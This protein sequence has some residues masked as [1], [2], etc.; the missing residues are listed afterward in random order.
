MRRRNATADT[1]Q[2]PTTRRRPGRRSG[3]T[4]AVVGVLGAVAA[5]GATAGATTV[6]SSWTVYHGTPSGSGVGTAVASVNTGSRAWTSPVLSGQL[7]GEPLV[8]NGKI[9]VATE[10]NRVYE[11]SP[12]TGKILWS[13]RIATPVPASAL[14]CG[15]IAPTVGITGTPVIDAAR[16]EIFVVADEWVHGHPEHVL[17]GLNTSNGKI[18]MVRAVDPRGQDPALLL[19]RTGLNLDAG[20]V[21]FGFGGNDGD[22]GNYR[23]RVVTV[24]ETGGTPRIFTIDAGAGEREGAIWMGGAA[25]E[26]D[27]KGH[28]WVEVGNGSVTSSRRTFDHSDAVLEFT[29]GLHLTQYFAPGTWAQDNATDNDLSTAPALLADGK[30]VAAGKSRTAYLLNANH[31]GGINHQQAT[32]PG[33]CDSIIAGGDAVVGTTVYL[34]CLSGPVALRVTTSPASLQ[35][36]WRARVGG[37]PP[38][39]VANRVW[40]IGQDGMLYGL[41]PASGAVRQQAAIGA[42]ANHFPTP[43]AGVGLLLAPAANRV[44]AFRAAPTGSARLH[45]AGLAPVFGS[46]GAG[47]WAAGAGALAAAL[48]LAGLGRSSR[49]RRSA[50]LGD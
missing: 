26:V 3:A 30:V 49:R 16:H 15:D 14:P 2:Q 24:R 27:A 42:V 17:V 6:L 8:S 45:G 37:G 43:S 34:P 13:R 19:Q 9:Y 5:G 18:R 39:V 46:D 41:D 20:R 28:I 35:V 44:V 25:P 38:I 21:V 32:L 10:A 7:Y 47:P 22:C 40:T 48:A 23:G 1:S 29:S 12:A 50:R 36:R 4:L 33:L 31:L 11:L